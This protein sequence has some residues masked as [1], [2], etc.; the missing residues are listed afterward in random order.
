MHLYFIYYSS[1]NLFQVKTNKPTSKYSMISAPKASF[2]VTLPAEGTVSL[3]SVRSSFNN[4]PQILEGLQFP[5]DLRS[6][7]IY[8]SSKN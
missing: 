5:R 8:Q 3:Y 4:D 6:K 1:L 7:C 2:C